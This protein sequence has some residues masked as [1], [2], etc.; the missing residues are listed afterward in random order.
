MRGLKFAAGDVG[1]EKVMARKGSRSEATATPKVRKGTANGFEVGHVG[2]A[3]T[4][5]SGFI[6]REGRSRAPFLE[7]L[8]Q[9]L[10]VELLAKAQAFRERRRT[11]GFLA[12]ARTLARPEGFEPPTLGFEDRL[13]ESAKFGALK[14]TSFYNIDLSRRLATNYDK[15]G[16]QQTL[17]LVRNGT[18]MGPKIRRAKQR[19]ASRRLGFA[20]SSSASSF[21]AYRVNADTH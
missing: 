6:P 8:R 7:L 21:R 14:E 19:A 3:P 4:Q 18:E 13:Q 16:H 2:L 12:I 5:P 9:R 11:H 20:R 1:R 15:I 10:A 17:F